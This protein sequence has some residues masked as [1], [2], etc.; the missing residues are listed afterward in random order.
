MNPDNS[1]SDAR[2]KLDMKKSGI[3]VT[4]TLPDEAPRPQPS[5]GGHTSSA[6]LQILPS[7]PPSFPVDTARGA[8]D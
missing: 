2:I 5:L 1:E 3:S 8:L 6:S 7:A 4:W